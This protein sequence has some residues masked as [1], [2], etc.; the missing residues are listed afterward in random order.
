MS[1]LD[2][3]LYELLFYLNKIKHIIWLAAIAA[4]LLASTAL[5]EPL[6]GA[7]YIGV[8]SPKFPC[9]EALKG[10]PR[11]VYNLGY[12]NETFGSNCG[13]VKRFQ[14]L[15]RG[16]GYVRVHAVNGTCFPSRGRTC[17]KGEFFHGESVK[18]ATK[19]LVKRESGV[20]PFVSKAFREY[21]PTNFRLC[22][23]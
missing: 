6:N 8:C 18:S 9:T 15:S 3:F 12:L 23:V 20:Y 2:I 14:R 4:V 21:G 16:Q 22:I 1:N 10:F 17:G 13:C 19:K 5:S 11:G 7:S